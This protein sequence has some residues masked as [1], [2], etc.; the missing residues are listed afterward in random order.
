MGKDVVTPIKLKP[1]LRPPP[2]FCQRLKQKNEERK[3]QNFIL[4]LKKLPINIPLIDSQEQMP[5][6][7]KFMKDLVM[8]KRTVSHEL[9]QDLHY[10]K[11]FATRSL[12][13]KKED[14]RAFT[15]SQHIRFF[16]FPKVVCDL[17]ASTSLCLLQYSSSWPWKP[18]LGCQCIY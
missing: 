1:I 13:Q 18:S 10:C 16:S 11:T 15:I 2:P 17:G 12:V 7:V 6:Y 9:A 4:M 8:K 5:R 14:L 3:F